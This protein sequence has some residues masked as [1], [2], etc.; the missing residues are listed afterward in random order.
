ML[1]GIRR[2]HQGAPHLSQGTAD[3][4]RPSFR[5]RLLAEL[6]CGKTEPSEEEFAALVPQQGDELSFFADAYHGIELATPETQPSRATLD[7]PPPSLGRSPSTTRTDTRLGHTRMA[8]TIPRPDR[9]T[10]PRHRRQTI[11]DVRCLILGHLSDAVLA[12]RALQASSQTSLAV[13][14]EAVRRGPVGSAFH[15][16]YNAILFHD[17]ME[18]LEGREAVVRAMSHP[19]NLHC[20][21]EMRLTQARYRFWRDICDVR[22][23][24]GQ[25]K[26]VLLLSVPRI[27]SPRSMR[28]SEK[29]QIISGLRSRLDDPTDPLERWLVQAWQLCAAIV[30]DQLPEESLMIDTY[31][32]KRHEAMTDADYEAFTSV[33]P[34]HKMALPRP[35]VPAV[36]RSRR[37][38][39]T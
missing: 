28:E 33:D 10:V 26:Y 24:W 30:A 19:V 21:R 14:W 12:R 16:R 2:I 32:L 35:S 11:T 7:S 31:H 4:V 29:N 15:E 6:L 23:E 20:L 9:L 34:R 27:S 38:P 3:D 13:L 17:R 18:A 39:E 8:T 22:R 36:G 1:L 25:R 5:A 37:E